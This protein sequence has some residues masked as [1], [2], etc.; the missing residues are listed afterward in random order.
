MRISQIFQRAFGS[1]F[2]RMTI[3]FPYHNAERLKIFTS[4]FIDVKIS[5]ESVTIKKKFSLQMF[6]QNVFTLT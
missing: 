2:N 3:W 1:S 6:N 4:Y 5:F